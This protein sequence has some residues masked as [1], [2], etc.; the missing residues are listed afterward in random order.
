MV[1]TLPSLSLNQA[2]LQTGVLAMSS[3]CAWLVVL[4]E[5]D[6]PAAQLHDF[7]LKVFDDPGDELVLGCTGSAG[8]NSKNIL[9]SP[10]RYSTACASS[11]PEVKPSLSAYQARAQL[12]VR[13][14]RADP[15]RDWTSGRTRT[16]DQ[17]SVPRLLATE[18]LNPPAGQNVR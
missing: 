13:T 17:P 12:A 5:L 7:C 15:E 8:G 3:P 4:L 10:L 1:S 16:A 2:A 9:S 14:G 6:A 11:W 18:G